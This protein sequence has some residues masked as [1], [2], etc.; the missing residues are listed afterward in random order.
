[1]EHVEKCLISLCTACY[2][3]HTSVVVIMFGHSCF[4]YNRRNTIL[5]RNMGDHHVANGSDPLLTNRIDRE[6]LHASDSIPW[7]LPM[8][9][10]TK[11]WRSCTSVQFYARSKRIYRA[12]ITQATLSIYNTT[13][14]DANALG[15]VRFRR[16]LSLHLYPST[17]SELCSCS[18]CFFKEVRLYSRLVKPFH[19]NVAWRV[20]RIPP[21]EKY[22]LVWR[23]YV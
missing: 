15:W 11:R 13:T 9:Q 8:G 22:N 20:S 6:P 12:R 19:E 4:K 14:T 17:F 23:G 21:K 1:M 18:E 3:R 2:P 7:P 10:T 16:R 5:W